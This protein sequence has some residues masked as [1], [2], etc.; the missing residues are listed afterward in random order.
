LKRKP[1]I[2]LL[3]IAFLSF[4]QAASA[5]SASTALANLPEADMLIYLSPQRIL[6]D[7]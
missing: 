7:R 3:L 5:Q 6:N 1:S 4:A 2:L